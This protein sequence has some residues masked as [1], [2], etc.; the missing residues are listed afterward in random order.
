VNGEVKQQH[1]CADKSA[2][3]SANV[4]ADVKPVLDRLKTL[5]MRAVVVKE[6][7][8][9]YVA[10]IRSMFDLVGQV[11]NAFTTVDEA[12]AFQK[13]IG[14]SI[15]NVISNSSSSSSGGISYG[16]PGDPLPPDLAAFDVYYRAHLVPNS[17]PEETMKTLTDI[18]SS[19]T[20]IDSS[21]KILPPG[22]FTNVIG[23]ESTSTGTSVCIML[24]LSADY[25]G[26][27]MP[28]PRP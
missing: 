26:A 3:D 23:A 6:N 9:W 20:F 22:D 5:S 17:A 28:C 15:T 1:V 13:W 25:Q 2:G 24:P 27:H 11:L 18:P 4:P 12:K 16:G 19:I 7:G 10:P 14:S 21:L 8:R